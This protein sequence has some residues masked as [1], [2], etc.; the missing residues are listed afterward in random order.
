DDRLEPLDPRQCL[1]SDSDGPPKTVDESL[2]CHSQLHRHHVDRNPSARSRER[3]GGVG[4]RGVGKVGTDASEES[5]LENRE[6]LLRRL[7]LE[8]LI[9]NERYPGL[10]EI[11]AFDDLIR[12][13]GDRKT[14]KRVR[15]AGSKAHA[16]QIAAVGRLDD[17]ELILQPG[18]PA[19]PIE[20]KPAEV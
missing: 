16:D 19:P 18:N 7:R 8:K 5:A 6:A 17:Q 11:A 4:D 15:A 14:E 20:G 13:L 10:E 12:Q 9:A 3:F 2:V 1:G